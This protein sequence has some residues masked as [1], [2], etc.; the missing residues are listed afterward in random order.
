MKLDQTLQDLL[1]HHAAFLE[2]EV[3]KGTVKVESVQNLMLAYDTSRGEY[4]RY[5]RSLWSPW[6]LESR[7]PV[8]S[9]FVTQRLGVCL[10]HLLT[11]AVF[12]PHLQRATKLDAQL[13]SFQADS[14]QT[15]VS[16]LRAA[17]E[18]C[19]KGASL[20]VE[21]YLYHASRNLMMYGLGL[22]DLLVAYDAILA[23]VERGSL[24]TIQ[25]E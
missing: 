25:G 9:H 2:K 23:E 10:F 13:G 11:L 24:D 4:Q 7:E 3:A 18:L 19:G 14:N 6:T 12:A 21:G 15:N 1:F 16:P 20:G 5:V 17:S 8:R 22:P